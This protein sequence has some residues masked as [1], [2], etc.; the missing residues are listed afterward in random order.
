GAAYAFR[1]VAPRGGLQSALP[2]AAASALMAAELLSLHREIFG[3]PLD[4]GAVRLAYEALR[5]GALGVPARA[6]V[7]FVAAGALVYGLLVLGLSM[8]TKLPR[9]PSLARVSA[10]AMLPAIALTGSWS[11]LHMNRSSELVPGVRSVAR[12]NPEASSL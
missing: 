11:A 9:H 3:V 4:I 12:G 1:F 6:V 5:T 2:R 7:A 10:R 8:L